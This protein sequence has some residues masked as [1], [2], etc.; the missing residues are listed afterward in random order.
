MKQKCVITGESFSTDD[1]KLCVAP[2]TVK[3]L[4]YALKR[5]EKI[6]ME[7]VSAAL[8]DQDCVKAIAQAVLSCKAKDIGL[9]APGTVAEFFR[10]MRDTL[11][12]KK[13]RKVSKKVR[14]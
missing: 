2:N 8:Q 4:L 5:N 1:E 11:A 3:H 9:N 10:R 7:V 14:E 12:S 6:R 13:S